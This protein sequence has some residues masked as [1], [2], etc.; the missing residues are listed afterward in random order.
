[1]TGHGLLQYRTARYDTWY[2]VGGTIFLKVFWPC[3][4]CMGMGLVPVLWYRYGT[5]RSLSHFDPHWLVI[6][7]QS[8]LI[9]ANYGMI[10]ARIVYCNVL[11]YRMPCHNIGTIAPSARDRE[12]KVE[13]NHTMTGSFPFQL[14]SSSIEDRLQ[15]Q[16]PPVTG[17]NS[18]YIIRSAWCLIESIWDILRKLSPRQPRI[19]TTFT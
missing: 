11:V 1:M 14:Y 15:V 2:Q 19:L 9:L 17:S 10:P 5:V 18:C 3:G 16:E 4:L 8:W 7:N 6:N 12:P 13:W